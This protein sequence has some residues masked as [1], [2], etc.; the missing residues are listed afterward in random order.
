MTDND[1]KYVYPLHVRVLAI[2]IILSLA[3]LCLWV[4]TTAIVKLTGVA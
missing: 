4:V 3:L 2:G 1:Y